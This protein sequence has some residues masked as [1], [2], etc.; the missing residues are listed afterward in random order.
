MVRPRALVRRALLIGAL[1]AAGVPASA[2]FQLRGPLD[3]NVVGYYFDHQAGPG[4]LDW[5][6]E[7]GG[8]LGAG[9]SGRAYDGHRGTDFWAYRNAP[10]YAAACGRVTYVLD[11]FPD[12][13]LGNFDGGGFGNQ[14]WIEHADGWITIY[15]HLQAGSI[16]VQPGQRIGA[17]DRVGGM[18]TSGNSSGLHLH[19]EVRH[20]GVPIDPFF[21]PGGCNNTGQ[22]SLWTAQNW[23][24]PG[25]IAP[26]C[27]GVS[28]NPSATGWAQPSTVRAGELVHLIV[29]VDRGTNP[30]STG[31]IVTAV[32]T[33]IREAD[34]VPLLD[35]GIAGGCDD[36]AGDN[37]FIACATVALSTAPGLAV[38]PVTVRD[39]QNRT[40]LAFVSIVVTPPS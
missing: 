34:S 4:A 38:L 1:L 40:A 16:T 20:N 17:G 10:V 12:G 21:T 13:Y 14:V 29:A 5:K 19:F 6:C 22:A 3:N 7:I 9:L 32:G 39:A 37:T 33:P 27:P 36:I 24:R 31:L 15:G 11:G 26:I 23:D 18:G 30:T 28:T 35:T 8:T 25:T 2:E